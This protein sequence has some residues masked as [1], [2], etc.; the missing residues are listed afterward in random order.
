MREHGITLSTIAV[1]ADADLKLL[2]QL[3]A[4]GRGRF[5]PVNDPTRLP[6]VFLKEASIVRRTLIHEDRRGIPLKVVDA[7]DELLAEMNGLPP[8]FGQVLVSPKPDPRARLTLASGTMAD[9]VLAH[10]QSGLGKAL[11]FTGDVHPKWGANWVG[12][13]GFGSF[14]ARAIRMVSRSEMS[15]NLDAEMTLDGSRGHLRVNGSDSND[16]QDA[17]KTVSGVVLGPE[18]TGTPVRLVQTGPDTF[19][20]DFTAPQTGVYVANVS[21][22]DARGKSGFIIAGASQNDSP[23]MRDLQSNEQ[24]LDEVRRKTGGRW[25]NSWDAQEADVF[26]RDGLYPAVESASA[27]ET[28][29]ALALGLMILDVAVRRIAW[30]W[31]TIQTA[32]HFA[33]ERMGF[34]LAVPAVKS[35]TSVAALREV[36]QR[37]H[38]RSEKAPQLLGPAIATKNTRRPDSQVQRNPDTLS[39]ADESSRADAAAE[40]NHTD[41]LLDAKQRARNRMRRRQE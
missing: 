10:W 13:T 17:L 15:P 36:R 26:R 20:G 25:I 18:L 30:D 29:L 33:V 34:S 28:L 21:Y 16:S 5:Y 24:K 22:Q 38:E 12:S 19:E 27:R 31:Q 9:P 40:T 2:A 37:T 23:E 6:Q 7:S 14:W 39:P 32:A 3:A 4:D 41:A 35:T 11:V 8:L 1:G